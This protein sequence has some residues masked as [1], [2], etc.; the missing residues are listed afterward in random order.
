VEKPLAATAEQVQ[1]IRAV[2]RKTGLTVSVGFQ[3]LYPQSTWDIKRLLL[4]GRLGTIES[5]SLVGLWPRPASYYSRNDWAGRL[6]Q[7]GQPVMD[8][9]VNNAFAHFIN[10]ALFWAGDSLDQSG[11]V[12]GLACELYRTHEIESF[13]TVCARAR[14][15]N[16]ARLCF[17]LTHSCVEDRT[18]RLIV[19]G[20]EGTLAWTQESDY[21]LQ[22]RG[23]L[24]ERYAIPQKFETKLQMADAIVARMNGQAARVCT[25]EI[26]LEHARVVEA[27]HTA[28]PIHTL[29]SPW[30]EHR[31]S[32]QEDWLQIK[33]IEA[34]CDRGTT[35]QLLWSEQKLPWS[36]PAS[37]WTRDR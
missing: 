18:P 25:T 4:E 6:Y 30:L 36:Q 3:D 31:Q 22:L 35:E 33:G 17:F 8:S 29:S 15:S 14:L 21:E 37:T 32:Q 27:M 24:V 2:E 11:T 16:Q 19:K 23:G 13:D 20:T 10:L 5:F 34:A 12:E 28:A 9:P 26:A 7:K 1:T